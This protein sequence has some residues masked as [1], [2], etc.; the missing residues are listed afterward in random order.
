MIDEQC[1]LALHLGTYAA[2][3]ENMLRRMVDEDF[4]GEKYWLHQVEIRLQPGELSPGVGGELSG[5]FGDVPLTKL[6]ELGAR[7]VRYVNT[8]ESVGSISLVIDPQVITRIRTIPLPTEAAILPT[9][10]AATQAVIR[11][12]S[13]LEAAEHLRPDTTGVPEDQILHSS[14]KATLAARR[15]L[16]EGRAVEI[17]QQMQRY[18]GRQAA[19]SA[20]LTDAL[21]NA[22][23]IDV[24]TQVREKFTSVLPT[25]TDPIEYHDQFRLMA[26]LLAR[27]DTVVQ[28]FEVASR[29]APIR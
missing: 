23:L 26:G 7:A 5:W 1:A 18:R 17:A 16:V 6:T 12:T 13:D 22:Y 9:T 29:R 2:A 14:L 15:G 19:I 8:H 10:A 24:N 21:A 28:Q 25:E 27:P 4:S 3:V 20:S 11:A